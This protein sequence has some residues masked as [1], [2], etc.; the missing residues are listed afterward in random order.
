MLFPGPEQTRLDCVSPEPLV[1]AP[2]VT[3]PENL[4]DIESDDELEEEDE[5]KREDTV[6]I[7]Q[8]TKDV[9]DVNSG[10]ERSPSKTDDKQTNNIVEETTESNNITDEVTADPEGVGETQ[11]DKKASE[12]VTEKE[13]NEGN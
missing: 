4:S 7:K 11:E 12:T 5:I 3:L 1:P 9:E 8:E 10:V 6:N 2:P 13:A